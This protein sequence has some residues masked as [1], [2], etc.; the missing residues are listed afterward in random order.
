ML[1]MRLV[2]SMVLSQLTCCACNDDVRGVLWRGDRELCRFAW[3]V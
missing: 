3:L 1:R 2:E